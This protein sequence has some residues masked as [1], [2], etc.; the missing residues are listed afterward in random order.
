MAA[1][2][3]TDAHEASKNFTI[4]VKV[5]DTFFVETKHL[6]VSQ[7]CSESES[8]ATVYLIF[9]RQL[10]LKFAEDDWSYYF[11]CVGCNIEGLV[12]KYNAVQFALRSRYEGDKHSHTSPN[13]VIL[14]SGGQ[15]QGRC[16]HI[17]QERPQDQ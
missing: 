5:S 11:R 10:Y 4:A 12:K 8:H 14:E 1:M 7:T 6:S 3:S 13:V 9:G 15:H 16:R 2:A 17:S